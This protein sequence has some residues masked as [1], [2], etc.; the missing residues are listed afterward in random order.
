[1]RVFYRTFFTF[2]SRSQH[3]LRELV[4]N[5]FYFPSMWRLILF[6]SISKS[7]EKISMNFMW[8]IRHLKKKPQASL[9]SQTSKIHRMPNSEICSKL[10]LRFS[11]FVLHKMLVSCTKYT[12]VAIS[13]SEGALHGRPRVF[14]S[15]LR[16]KSYIMCIASQRCRY[17]W[18][19]VH[20]SNRYHTLTHTRDADSSNSRI[21]FVVFS[22][23]KP[24]IRA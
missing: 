13:W 15:K 7:V 24:I 19:Y 16:K 22:T 5:I 12:S 20:K 1:M 18:L 21:A 4:N 11:V 10:D 3:K 6:R 14:E 23:L 8:E 2:F 9:K 17:N